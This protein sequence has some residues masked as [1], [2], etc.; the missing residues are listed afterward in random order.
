MLEEK[1]NQ[2]LKAA[3]LGGDVFSVS[4]LR[5]L[6]SAIL[7]T[8]IASGK[9]D[10]PMSDADLISLLQKEA[11]KRQE[12]ADLYKQ[13]GDEARAKTELTEKGL[14]EKYLPAQLSEEEIIKLVDTA[15][16]EIGD[17]DQ[18]ALGK[19]IG[20][21]KQQTAGKA[22]GATIARITQQRINQ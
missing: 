22:D 1:I 11:K 17:H 2:D 4:T 10:E 14:I 7:N 3:M 20:L 21:V 13:G 16:Q 12:S 18:S 8:K 19:V 5:I 9:R 6:K 15:I